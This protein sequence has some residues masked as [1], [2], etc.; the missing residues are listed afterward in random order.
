MIIHI[1]IIILD[2]LERAAAPAGGAARLLRLGP[3][4]R[5]WTGAPD[6]FGG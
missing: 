1:N 4:R 6:V 2:T 3:E 5:I